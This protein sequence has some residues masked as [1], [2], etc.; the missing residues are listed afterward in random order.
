MRLNCIGVTEIEPFTA[1]YWECDSNSVLEVS[2]LTDGKYFLRCSKSYRLVK[3]DEEG[4]ESWDS[5]LVKM[6]DYLSSKF[7]SFS[8]SVD[9]CDTVSTEVVDS[10]KKNKE[11][12]NRAVKL[13]KRVA[14]LRE[15]RER[16]GLAVDNSLDS[17]KQ[18]MNQRYENVDQRLQESQ[19]QLD[20]L[21]NELER[22]RI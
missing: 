18:E 13:K 9:Y 3:Q 16:L 10:N 11:L 8:I 21:M 14:N 4:Q 15:E 17:F 22:K 6:N 5:N 1:F 2:H 12:V 19:M 20:Q 7:S